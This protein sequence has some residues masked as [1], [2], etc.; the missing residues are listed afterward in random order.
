M[1]MDMEPDTIS[2]KLELMDMR[3]ADIQEM[4]MSIGS[5]KIVA[6]LAKR[7]AN[8]ENRRLLLK[9]A[10]EAR[11]KELWQIAAIVLAAILIAIGAYYSV[12]WLR[13][14][15]EAKDGEELQFTKA[16]A[17]ELHAAVKRNYWKAWL[18][19]GIPGM[20]ALWGWRRLR[21]IK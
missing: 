2:E 4:L 6:E 5:R 21:S 18:I 7:A 17:D 16:E 15:M 12:K 9:L 10:E 8:K 13:Q 3:A 19:A 11:Q 1:K 20:A 14:R